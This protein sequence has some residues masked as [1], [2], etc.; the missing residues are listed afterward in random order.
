MRRARELRKDMSLPEVLLW[1]RLRR[2]AGSAKF[3]RQHPIGGYIL[4]FYCAEARLAI[5]I[6]GEAH[7]RGSRPERDIRRDKELTALGLKVLRIPATQILADVNAAAEAIIALALPLHRPVGGPPPHA[8]HGE[9]FT[10]A[11]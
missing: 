4:D 8:L 7:S 2:R 3:R 1:Q 6:D 9:D 11:P 5:E 10:G